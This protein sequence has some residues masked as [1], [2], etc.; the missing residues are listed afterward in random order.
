MTEN[1]TEKKLFVIE[2]E[3]ETDNVTVLIESLKLAINEA[4]K[5]SNNKSYKENQFSEKY[6][7]ETWI[8]IIGFSIIIFLIVIGLIIGFFIWLMTD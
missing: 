6:S 8:L 1:F 3:K 5:N 4:Q 7:C 2:E